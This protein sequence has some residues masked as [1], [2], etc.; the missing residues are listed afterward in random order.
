VKALL[1]SYAGLIATMF[2]I[3]FISSFS[4]YTPLHV[5]A[6]MGHPQ[7]EYKQSLMHVITPTTDPFL[8]Y[9]IYTYI[10]IYIFIFIHVSYEFTRLHILLLHLSSSNTLLLIINTGSAEQGIPA[11]SGTRWFF[12]ILTK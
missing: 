3:V 10:F 9:I 11:V 7:V 5:W 2:S 8:G 1:L 12:I 6:L 4:F